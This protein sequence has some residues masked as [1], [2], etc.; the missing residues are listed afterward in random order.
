MYFICSSMTLATHHGIIFYYES[1]SFYGIYFSLRDS[2]YRI[3][4]IHSNIFISLTSAVI[5]PADKHLTILTDRD[6]VEYEREWE[7]EIIKSAASPGGD[8]ANEKKTLDE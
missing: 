4:H 1:I 8:F 2:S 3:V 6:M 5:R 7:R